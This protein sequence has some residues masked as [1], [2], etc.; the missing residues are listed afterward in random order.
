MA[1]VTRPTTEQF[2]GHLNALRASKSRTVNAEID[3][4]SG[5]YGSGKTF[6]GIVAIS[7]PSWSGAT[8]TFLVYLDNHDNL[9]LNDTSSVFPTLCT[10]I[11]R[12]TLASGVIMDM[13]DEREF[14]N[15]LLDAYQVAID[16]FGLNIANPADDMQEAI[17]LLD[18]YVWN[19]NLEHGVNVVKYVD[20]DVS[21][22]IKNGFVRN[23]HLDDAPAIE[24]PKR[25]SG[26][27]KIRYSTS[28]PNDWVDETDMLIR[29][30][31]SPEDSGLGNVNWRV[32]YRLS[33]SGTNID[34]SMST[35][36]AIQSAPGVMNRLVDTGNDLLIP[37]S[38]ITAGSILIISIEREYSASDT[39][40][41]TTRMH[42]ARMEYVGR[43]IL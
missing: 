1:R 19:L 37:W 22:G 39:Y 2:Q 3:I 40:E 24:F 20:L 31:W 9:V 16:D 23:S 14:V 25:Q 11:A 6:P 26:I 33:S 35:V 36:S 18:A 7:D 41:S 27:G 10:K 29:V 5:N 28:I 4:A 13:I 8:D 32:S 38:D 21:D 42:L 15:G 12:V 17:E 34:N 43:G 30:F